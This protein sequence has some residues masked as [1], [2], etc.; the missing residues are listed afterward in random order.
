MPFIPRFI[1]VVGDNNDGRMVGAVK[2]QVKADYPQASAGC[3][4]KDL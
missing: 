3:E 1:I 2:I 4:G